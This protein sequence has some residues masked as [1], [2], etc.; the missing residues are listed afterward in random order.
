VNARN[1][2]GNTPVAESKRNGKR[3]LEALLRQH[4]GQ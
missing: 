3:E 2:N 1:C 4:G